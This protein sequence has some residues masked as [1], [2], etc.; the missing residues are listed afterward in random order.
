METYYE[1]SE[2]EYE[3]M[4]YFWS[5]TQPVQFK[6]ILTYFN[7][8]KEKDWKKQTLGT[9]LKFLQDKKFLQVDDTAFR[10]KYAAAYSKEQYL[11]NQAVAICQTSFD[12]SI[13]KFIAAFSGGEK[14][15][16]QSVRELKEYLKQYE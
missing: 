15:D 11:H 1:L 2:T 6:D 8:V 13:G 10:K 3:I 16:D 7:T 9:Y 14:L 5:I 12:N 4:E